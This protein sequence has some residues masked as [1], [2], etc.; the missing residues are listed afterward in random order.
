M[1]DLVSIR[2]SPH[3]HERTKTLRPR[4]QTLPDVDLRVIR[5][6][7]PNL[8]MTLHLTHLDELWDILEEIRH[9]GMTGG[10]D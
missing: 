3:P 6:S 8:G 7:V 1:I 10:L 9:D 4:C 2:F 5:Q